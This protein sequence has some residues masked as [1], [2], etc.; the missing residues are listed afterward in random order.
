MN[1]MKIDQEQRQEITRQIGRMNVLSISGGRV[2]AIED[3]I[4]LPVSNGYSVR[5]QLTAMDDYTVS[6]IF[7]R[8]GKEWVKGSREGV[9][10]DEVSEMAYRAGMFRSYGENGWMDGVRG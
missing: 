8:A 9:Y 6:R 4:E 5:V 10:C 7:R 1:T 2:V 3:G